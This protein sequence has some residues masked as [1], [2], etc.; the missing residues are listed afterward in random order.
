MS[1]KSRVSKLEG[2][3]AS[4]N[5]GIAEFIEILCKSQGC[6]MPDELPSAAEVDALIRS[7]IGTALRPSSE[8]KRS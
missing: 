5:D 6:A 7:A 2:K 4:A 8:K 1:V 3:A